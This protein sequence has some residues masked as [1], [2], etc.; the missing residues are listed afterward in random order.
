M[1]AISKMV[2]NAEM[3]QV[4][5][6]NFKTVVSAIGIPEEGGFYSG[7]ILKA[8]D[9]FYVAIMAQCG[10]EE[11]PDELVNVGCDYLGV[12]YF[13]IWFDI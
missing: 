8:H 9:D 11:D 2:K 10:D 5:A 1:P 4:A 3:L 13:N 12:E 6:I 7:H